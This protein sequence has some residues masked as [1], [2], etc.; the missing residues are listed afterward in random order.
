MIVARSGIFFNTVMFL[1]ITYKWGIWPVELLL[2]SK[3]SNLLIGY[4]VHILYRYADLIRTIAIHIQAFTQRDISCVYMSVCIP[5]DILS[6]I[7]CYIHASGE[8]PLFPIKK[9]IKMFCLQKLDDRNKIG[10]Y[11]P[12]STHA[13]L[14]CIMFSS[15]KRNNGR[16]SYNK[17]LIQGIW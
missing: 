15:N 3:K 11:V 13:I 16:S 12:Y 5:V 14:F 6:Y 7:W 4:S 2:A 10:L 17:L 8:Q 1:Q 9:H